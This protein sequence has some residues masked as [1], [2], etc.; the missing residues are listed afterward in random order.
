MPKTKKPNR[1][2]VPKNI[3]SLT[4][5]KRAIADASIRDAL[6][7]IV[8]GQGKPVS[9]PFDHLDAIAESHRLVMEVDHDKRRVVLR[10]EEFKPTII[11]F[12]PASTAAQED[13]TEG[14]IFERTAAELPDGPPT[15]QLIGLKPN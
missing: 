4:P 8:V 13:A 3:A 9:I 11:G 7:A 12:D 1:K 10:S 2:P 6:L 5:T 15:H 14:D